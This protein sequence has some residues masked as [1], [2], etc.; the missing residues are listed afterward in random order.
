MG[1]SVYVMPLQTYLS[2]AFKTTWETRSES[3][4]GAPGFRITP[5]G[6]ADPSERPR[7]PDAEVQLAIKRFR[8][9]V[10]Q[11]V[12]VPLEWDEETPFRNASSLSYGSFGGP[13]RR[14][15]QWAYRVNLPR[16]RAMSAPQIWLPVVFEPTIRV[17][18]PWD[19][20][21]EIRIVSSVGL[22]S[23]FD[24]LS[25]LMAEEPL[26]KELQALPEGAALEGALLELDGEMFTAGHLRRIAELS[27][28][29]R[30]PVIVEG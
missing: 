2:G 23:E 1:V 8:K 10:G 21:S 26:M 7:R 13:R 9:A 18:P 19:E 24:R 20:E 27:V 6:I 25:K 3:A 15:E 4:G 14:A 16:L 17:T 11:F 12:T 29:H 5:E 28:E 30:V 22:L